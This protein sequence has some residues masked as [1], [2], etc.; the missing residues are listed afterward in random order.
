MSNEILL[1]YVG[2]E[3][4]SRKID[5]ENGVVR[6]VKILGTKSRNNR[7]YPIETL[8]KASPL[9]ENAKVNVN[10]PDGSAAETRKYQDRV[11]SIKNVKFSENGLYG[12]FYFNPK[13]PL[14]EQ[15]IWDAERSP[16]NL[17]FSHNVEA[18]VKCENGTQIVEEIKRV[19]SVDIVADPATTS[20]LFESLNQIKTTRCDDV[21]IQNLLKKIAALETQRDS[22][23]QRFEI[24]RKL[25]EQF[26]NESDCDAVRLA[27]KN[28]AFLEIL[29]E[30]TDVA[31]AQKII[32]ERVATIREALD[33][34]VKQKESKIR[35]NETVVSKSRND[36]Y[37]AESSTDDFVAAITY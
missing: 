26:A 32:A 20:G 5:K 35:E 15:L 2:L 36:I 7:V 9:Y 31:A 6:G 3:A 33:F 21:D 4:P 14:A 12:D 11:G 18:V 25:L 30:S 28:K 37:N 24:A 22:S 23:T 10:H 29:F 34:S 8:K 1:E 13:H 19:R 27:F 17:G 16:E